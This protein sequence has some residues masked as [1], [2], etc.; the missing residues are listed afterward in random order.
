LATR[1]SGRRIALGAA[2]EVQGSAKRPPSAAF[3]CRGYGHDAQVVCNRMLWWRTGGCSNTAGGPALRDRGCAGFLWGRNWFMRTIL[4]VDDESAARYG[5]G[6]ALEKQYQVIEAAS[7]GAAREALAAAAPDLILLDLVMPG[8]DGLSFLRWLR[9]NGHDVP[10]LVVSALDTA[11][12]AVEALQSGAADYIVKGFDIEELRRRVGNLLQLSELAEENARLRRE[13][14]ADGQ[15]GRLLGASDAMR[16]VFEMAERVATS[17]ATVLILGE[18]GTGKDLLAQEI[19]ERSARRG[20]AFVAVNCAALPENLIESELF[21]YERGAFTGAAQQRKGKFELASGGTIFL[22]EIGDMNAVTQAKVL[23]ALENRK[24]ERLGGSRPMDVDVRVIS[25][26]HRD[27][28]GEIAA[29]RFRE[30]L[31]YRLRVVT[32]ELP[33]LRAHKEDLAMLVETFLAQLGARHKHRAQVTP[34][35]MS[36]LRS[37]DWPGNVRELRNALERTLVLCDGDEITSTDLPEEIREYQGAR[38]ATTKAG[39][40]SFLGEADFREAKRQFEIVYLR[41]KLE[42]HHWNV[43]QTAAEVGLHRQSLQE[44]LRE[45]GIQRPGK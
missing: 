26:T 44:K 1:W 36:L 43:S 38:G 7:A 39:D 23:R 8:E 4:L 12:T 27:L 25:A 45:L 24:I 41:R 22:D 19:H 3:F 40:E 5:M 6:R 29:G 2:E 32:L 30:D 16:R 31:Y 13:L 17:D 28:P 18:S 10:V 34:E 33:P 37:Y 15:F 9:E 35:A 42:E 14:V 20:R 11:K 21:G